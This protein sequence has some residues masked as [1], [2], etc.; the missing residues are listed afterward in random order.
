MFTLPCLPLSLYAY[1]QIHFVK[2]FL[3]MSV[4]YDVLMPMCL[5]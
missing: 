3:E 5:L 4:V 1:M 2:T